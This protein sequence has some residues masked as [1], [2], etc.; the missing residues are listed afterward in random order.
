LTPVRFISADVLRIALFWHE[1]IDKKLLDYYLRSRDETSTLP[2]TAR[3]MNDDLEDAIGATLSAND[4]LV[5]DWIGETPGAW[6]ALAGKAVL[7]YRGWLGRRLT[8]SERR[9]VWSVLWDR[10]SQRK[11]ASAR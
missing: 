5:E 6:G 11:Q 7:V 8:A 10:L 1:R 3:D 2:G 9:M 4:A